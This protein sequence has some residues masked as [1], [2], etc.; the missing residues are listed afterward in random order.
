MQRGFHFA[1][2]SSDTDQMERF[3]DEVIDILESA[4]QQ[5]EAARTRFEGIKKA[6]L[7]RLI[8]L[9]DSPEAIANR[10]AG[11]LFAGASLMDEI[12][13]LE[14]ITIDDLYQ[15]AKKFITPQ[16]ISVYQVVPQHQ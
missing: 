15:V 14:T 8:G 9:L 2:F 12:A 16:G 10:Y 3:A 7:G 1:Y 5:I 6:E 4:D 13:T 11:D